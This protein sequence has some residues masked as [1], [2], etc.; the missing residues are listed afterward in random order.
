MA[1]RPAISKI[2][3]HGTLTEPEAHQAMGHIMD[4]EATPAQI[5][6]FITALR[7]G[8]QP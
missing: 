7:S 2:A 1:L 8:A 5:A 4:G 6:S 3:A